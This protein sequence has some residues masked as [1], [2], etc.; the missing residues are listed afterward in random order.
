MIPGRRER[1]SERFSQ[2]WEAALAR[3][4]ASVSG[5]AESLA[6]FTCPA[7]GSGLRRFAGAARQATCLAGHVTAYSPFAAVTA[8]W[9]TGAELEELLREAG[10]HSR[11][12]SASASAPVA[13]PAHGGVAFL[14]LEGEITGAAAA[15]LLAGIDRAE[16]GGA[17]CV[18]LT[19]NS[20]G[21]LVAEALRIRARLQAWQASG[22]QLVS[23]VVQASSA[24]SI[25]ALTAD[26]RVLEPE[27]YFSVHHASGGTDGELREARASLLDIY[28]AETL[29][30]VDVVRTYLDHEG[31]MTA[32]LDSLREGWA[33]EIG[34]RGD[35]TDVA[36]HVAAGGELPDSPRRRRVRIAV[37]SAETERIVAGLWKTG[38]IEMVNL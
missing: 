21:G 37:D 31:W 22:R 26:W 1:F 25:I 29:L 8:D 32:N 4:S 36:Q 7:C 27:G 15:K 24:A 16:A 38:E 14:A 5:A 13:Q 12:R 19:V 9:T 3:A 6:S 23:H 17:R 18:V 34:D 28:A 33:D 20:P 2:A 30:P 11:T 10:Q 35:A